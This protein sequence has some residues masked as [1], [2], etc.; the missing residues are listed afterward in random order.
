MRAGLVVGA[1]VGVVAIGYAVAEAFHPFGTGHLTTA[2]VVVTDPLNQQSVTSAFARA[3]EPLA[4]RLDMAADP[5]S[6][7]VAIYVPARQDIANPPFE[8]TLFRDIVSAEEHARAIKAA[9]GANGV[10]ER[11][12][13]AL[14]LVAP[15]MPAER[16]ARLQ[17][18]L[19]SLQ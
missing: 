11:V 4:I 8:L 12:R 15:T 5:G 9:A 18:A 14:L 3:G 2:A 10:V 13:N 7:I 6:P 1:T 19:E 16:R 17:S